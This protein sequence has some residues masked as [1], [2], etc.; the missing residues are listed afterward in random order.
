[1]QQQRPVHASGAPDFEMLAPAQR[2]Q[3]ERQQQEQ[4]QRPT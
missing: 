3:Q 1:M 2:W 4:Q